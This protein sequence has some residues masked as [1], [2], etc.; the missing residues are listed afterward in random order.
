MVRLSGANILAGYLGSNIWAQK[1]LT[2][3]GVVIGS[4][5]F[6][7]VKSIVRKDLLGALAA[8]EQLTQA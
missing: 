1:L 8:C 4:P 6:V 5:D 7:F 3:D 2:L